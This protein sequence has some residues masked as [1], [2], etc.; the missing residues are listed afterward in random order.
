[1]D[2]AVDASGQAG[3]AFPQGADVG[4]A[5][6][7]AGERR[8]AVAGLGGGC[9][10][11]RGIRSDRED[12]VAGAAQGAGRRDS[13]RPAAPRDQHVQSAS[14][15]HPAFRA[16]VPPDSDPVS[17]PVSVLMS[18]DPVMPAVDSMTGRIFF[19]SAS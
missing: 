6:E 7:V 16:W 18:D 12:P 17:V 5:G 14:G 11:A 3:N 13:R 19:S 1:M 15:T 2:N 8:D 9:L 4:Q 10:D